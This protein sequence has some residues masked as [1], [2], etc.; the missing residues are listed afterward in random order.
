MAQ[1]G[2]DLSAFT[3]P[4]AGNFS[5]MTTTGGSSV[6]LVSGELLPALLNTFG[7]ILLGYLCG[8]FKLMPR[9]ATSIVSKLCGMILLPVL[10]FVG[11]ATVDFYGP[12]FVP[13]GSPLKIFL[14]GICISKLIMFLLVS[15][16][17][18]LTD[19]SPDRWAKAGIRGIFVTQQN[20][21]SLGLPIFAALY[22]K[23][24]PELISL[25]F[26]AA[27]INLVLLNPAAFIM[28]EYSSQRKQGSSLTWKVLLKI[29][30]KVVRNPIT[31]SAFLG[32][33][34]NFFTQGQLPSILYT[35]PFDGFLGVI[36]SAFP[37]LSLFA[38]GLVIVG[39]L[40]S[41]HPRYLAVRVLSLCFAC[42][43]RVHW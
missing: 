11:L 23:S 14:I 16:L 12:A 31:W 6:S 13:A 21:F 4:P 36:K 32:L 19:R 28:M 8:V 1:L 9:T 22:G 39:K 18:L 20:D 33:I 15:V 27:P 43:L 7:S 40:K 42:A 41:L 35:A 24:N 10:L 29:L 2:L 30:L 34:V 5:N 3:T 25:V 38:L 26:L 37:F 17:C